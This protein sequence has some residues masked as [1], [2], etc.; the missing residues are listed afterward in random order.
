MEALDFIKL[1]HKPFIGEIDN[2]I[3]DEEGHNYN[4][5]LAHYVEKELYEKI[6]H[7]D[8][9]IDKMMNDKHLYCCFEDKAPSSMI[10]L[11]TLDMQE[12]NQTLSY[13]PKL[14]KLIL[15]HSNISLHNDQ[16]LSSLTLIR[17]S[18]INIPK[19]IKSLTVER[20]ENFTFPN[21]PHLEKLRLANVDFDVPY[22]PN[23]K[24]LTL[25]SCKTTIPNLNLTS[26]RIFDGNVKMFYPQTLEELRL[27]GE[28]RRRIKLPANLPNLRTLFLENKTVDVIPYYPNLK[29]LSLTLCN[30]KDIPYMELSSLMIYNSKIDVDISKFNTLTSLEINYCNKSKI[31]LEHLDKLTNLTNL[32][33]NNVKIDKL[34]EELVNLESLSINFAPIDK[35]P[36]TYTKLKKLVLVHTKINKLPEEF[37]NL[38][39][40]SVYD[41]PITELPNTYINLQELS[42]NAPIKYLPKEYVNLIKLSTS[43]CKTFTSLPDTYTKL[44]E[45]QLN[46]E[47]VREIPKTYKQLKALSVNGTRI[48]ELSNEFTELKKLDIQD[49]RIKIPSTYTKLEELS[50]DDDVIIPKEIKYLK[51][52]WPDNIKYDGVYLKRD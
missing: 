3:K 5:Y 20:Y 27:D 39:F 33:L 21:L 12:C 8:F 48:K 4:Y 45:L 7:D 43:K 44:E 37:T 18:K 13:Y 17:D 2:S 38:E 23:L 32:S 16:N 25:L 41:I 11:E 19:S 49:T 31:K 6:L 35:L 22:Y 36:K 28:N 9:T 52:I 1:T 47:N 14:K 24:N 30:V 10:E 40:L 50:V 26:L 51:Y 42:I 29:E 34:P 46:Y 15:H